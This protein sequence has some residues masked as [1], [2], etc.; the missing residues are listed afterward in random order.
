MKTKEDVDKKYAKAQKKL[1]KNCKH[2]IIIQE[3]ERCAATGEW[4][5][6]YIK[7]CGICG[8]ILSRR[9]FCAD[10]HK[11]IRDHEIC[12]M[13]FPGFDLCP[14]CYKNRDTFL[15]RLSKRFQEK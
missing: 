15:E 13:E 6:F 14:D 11:E 9:T 2:L 3:N 12:K 8:A 7:K 1:K 10:C 5:D 4:I